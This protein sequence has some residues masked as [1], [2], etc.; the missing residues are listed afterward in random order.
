MLGRNLDPK[1]ARTIRSS[2]SAITT[3]EVWTLK[4]LLRSRACHG[5]AKQYVPEYPRGILFWDLACVRVTQDA[6]KIL[7]GCLGC[8][9][10]QSR[11]S[12]FRFFFCVAVAAA[13]TR[14]PCVFL[15]KTDFEAAASCSIPPLI[16]VWPAATYSATDVSKPGDRI[17]KIY[18]SDVSVAA[19]LDTITTLG[20]RR[21]PMISSRTLLLK[22]PRAGQMAESDQESSDECHPDRRC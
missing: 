8:R 15:A 19:S 1:H 22:S 20:L 10:N 11:L 14:L 4:S 21:L 18:Q 9:D 7:C 2:K 16:A 13:S 17:C 3:R 5:N 12:R 6:M